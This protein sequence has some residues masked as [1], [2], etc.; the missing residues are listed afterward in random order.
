MNGRTD[1]GREQ[2]RRAVETAHEAVQEAHA[3]LYDVELALERAEGD[4]EFAGVKH[5]ADALTMQRIEIAELRPLLVPIVRWLQRNRR[6][7]G[8]VL[9]EGGE[10]HG[11]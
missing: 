3:R 7:I 6:G 9:A 4:A 5:T 10:R 2:L 11:A 8:S 1:N